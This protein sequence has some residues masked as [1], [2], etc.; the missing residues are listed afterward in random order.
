MCSG[1][2]RMGHTFCSFLCCGMRFFTQSKLGEDV[3][4]LET[5]IYMAKK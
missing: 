3:K 5:V 2:R 4:G 1:G